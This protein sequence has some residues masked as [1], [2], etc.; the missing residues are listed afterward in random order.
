MKPYVILFSGHMID[1]AERETP[2]FPKEK[3]GS[4]KQEIKTKVLK[5]LNTVFKKD[6][7]SE[8]ELQSVIGVAG[9]ACGGDIL[10]HEVCQEL[11]IPTQVLLA[12]PREKFIAKSVRPGGKSWIARFKALEADPNITFRLFSESNE[13]SNGQQSKD[14]SADFWEQ[15]NLWILNTALTM[16]DRNLTFI[17]LWDGKKGDG[18]GGT[19]NMIREV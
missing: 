13:L 3:E 19:E 8:D 11:G 14:S 1:T 7:F 16:G 10:F 18:P 17:A 5:I 15:N 6:H 4:V 2:R 12:L 9:G